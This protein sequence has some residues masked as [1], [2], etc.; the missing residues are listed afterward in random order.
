[1]DTSFPAFR[2]CYLLKGYGPAIVYF[3]RTRVAGF[4]DILRRWS[5]GGSLL[6]AD[7]STTADEEDTV[8]VCCVL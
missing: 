8:N 1:M 7:P 5:L 2:L 4:V 6:S 3:I